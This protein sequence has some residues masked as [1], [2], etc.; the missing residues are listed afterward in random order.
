MN[1]NDL[2]PLKPLN[3]DIVPSVYDNNFSFLEELIEISKRVNSILE[4]LKEFNIEEIEKYVDSQINELKIYIDNQDE[5]LLSEFNGIIRKVYI[6]MNELSNNLKNYTDSQIIT[7]INY[8]NSVKNEI[9]E[10]I[11][12]IVVGNISVFNPTS[13]RVEPLD[14]V[15][16]DIYNTFRTSAITCIEFDELLL[17]AS[18]FDS[19]NITAI[20]FD[21]Y[22]KDLLVLP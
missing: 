8:V 7:V 10:Q 16:N 5:Q 14:K 21:L 11:Q 17:S 1:L 13:G 3:F 4:Y 18:S 15:L 9:E 12:S 6:D 2:I 19:K 22:G 20:D